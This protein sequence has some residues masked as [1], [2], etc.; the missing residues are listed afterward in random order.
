MA[1]EAPLGDT[2]PF[3]EPGRVYGGPL[4]TSRDKDADGEGEDEDEDED[5]SIPGGFGGHRGFG[6][7][8]LRGS[9]LIPV[10]GVDDA[11]DADAA[12][13]DEGEDDHDSTEGKR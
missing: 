2:A 6:I 7:L 1:R 5:A 9:A 8:P 11:A 13:Q 10:P 4:P 12:D 3:D